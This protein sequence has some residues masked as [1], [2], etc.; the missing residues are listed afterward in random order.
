M[1]IKRC[2]VLIVE[3]DS[4]LM[5]V[6]VRALE[7]GGI[8]N[9]FQASNGAEAL[10][11][12]E[13]NAERIFAVILDLA[14]PDMTGMHVVKHLLNV[15]KHHVGIIIFTGCEELYPAA[16]FSKVES[17]YVFP[18]EY[19]IKPAKLEKLINEVKRTFEIIAKKRGDTVRRSQSAIHDR[20]DRIEAVL[21]QISSRQHGMLAE[22]GLD[23]IR[24]ILIT[25]ALLCALYFGIGDFI[26]SV[27]H[28]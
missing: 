16:E 13:L 28:I 8:D 21:Q 12:L 25:V 26:K 4:N 17:N 6:L 1:D 11:Q 3:D 18:I 5:N 9:V 23:L 15:H 22:L 7:L 10:S 24:G 2:G 20:L 27:F 14:L 19:F